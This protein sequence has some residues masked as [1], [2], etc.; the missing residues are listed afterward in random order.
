MIEKIN[1]F[2]PVY[3]R[4][5]S[6]RL[7]VQGLLETR[8]SPG[9]DVRLIFIDNKSNDSLREYLTKVA[10]ENE[11]VELIL[12]DENIGKAKAVIVATEKY[13]DF[14]WFVNCDSDII[15]LQ[16][17]WPGLLADCYKAIKGAG[18]VATFYTYNGNNPQPPQPSLL[19]I[20]VNG[21]VYNFRWGGGVA[22]GCFITRKAM[23]EEV[24]YHDTGSVYGGV[25]GWFRW[26]VAHNGW[27]CGWIEQILVEH[28]NDKSK[29]RE[30]WA[31]KAEVQ[32]RILAKG[33]LTD[34][35]ELG[36]D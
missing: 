6:V 24:G 17:G 18:M 4:E 30:Y 34:P 11:G 7:C 31:W 20:N 1:V 25:D 26:N 13:P 15:P 9:Y 22:G 27:K 2:I 10:S 36:N 8:E 33:V 19:P 32:N 5:D 28:V 14:D 29:Y 3:F 35:K 23:W 12:L 16:K 21:T